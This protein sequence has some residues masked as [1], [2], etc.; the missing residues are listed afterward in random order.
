MSRSLWDKWFQQKPP[1]FYD[2][3]LIKG[4]WPVMHSLQSTLSSFDG[5]LLFMRWY[6]E[7][8][9]HGSMKW[10]L[11]PHSNP[12]PNTFFFWSPFTPSLHHQS[13]SRQW[14]F[15]KT[16]SF[17][18]DFIKANSFAHLNAMITNFAQKHALKIS[19]KFAQILKYVVH[20]CYCMIA[21]FRK[22]DFLTKL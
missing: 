18:S 7:Y 3:N 9:C 15:L 5:F 4:L 1:L 19:L 6:F 20:S 13:F 12:H 8:Q 2:L 22:S 14:Y 11:N 21:A 17:S 16:Y 10:T